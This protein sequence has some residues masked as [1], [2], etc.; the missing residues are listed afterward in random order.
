MMLSSRY[1]EAIRSAIKM[2]RVSLNSGLSQFQQIGNDLR[3][4]EII[5]GI[6]EAVTI[7]P[8]SKILIMYF[9]WIVICVDNLVVLDLL[10]WVR[11][12]FPASES[13]V[14]SDGRDTCLF[15]TVVEQLM[16]PNC[17]KPEQHEFYWNSVNIQ[18]LLQFL[19]PFFGKFNLEVD[20]DHSSSSLW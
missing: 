14:I 4:I 8:S 9:F 7:R 6:F 16:E 10:E 11:E 1:R 20:L 12:C 2:L 17:K 15:G 5:W 19:L 18:H 13:Q 3:G